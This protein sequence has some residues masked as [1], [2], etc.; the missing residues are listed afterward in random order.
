LYFDEDVEGR[1]RFKAFAVVRMTLIDP[2]DGTSKVVET[3]A[4]KYYTTGNNPK[5]ELIKSEI[6]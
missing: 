2:E 3:S 5:L 6:R 4:S 1:S